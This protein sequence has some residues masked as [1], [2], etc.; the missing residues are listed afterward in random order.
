MIKLEILNYKVIKFKRF[1]LVYCEKNI[2]RQSM[3]ITRKIWKLIE[4]KSLCA[5]RIIF[6]MRKTHKFFKM[7]EFFWKNFMTNYYNCIY[8]RENILN[9]T[10]SRPLIVPLYTRCFIH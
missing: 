8:T 2:S 6:S 4:N 7:G 3:I 5:R 9:S 1:V 10:K